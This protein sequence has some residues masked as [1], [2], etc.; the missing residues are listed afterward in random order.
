MGLWRDRN[1]PLRIFITLYMTKWLVVLSLVYAL[2]TEYRADLL[3]TQH[4]TELMLPAFTKDFSL[5]VTQFTSNSWVAMLIH[6]SIWGILLGLPL[7]TIVKAWMTKDHD[8][9]R[10]WFV[11]CS[12][13]Q[14]SLVLSIGMLTYIGNQLPLWIVGQ[15]AP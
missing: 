11:F 13:S 1:L 12:L 10:W 5:A 15:P 9:L 3:R 14:V 4:A 2:L 6:F 7:V 8:R